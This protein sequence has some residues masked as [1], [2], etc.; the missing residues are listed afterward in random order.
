[1]L[2]TQ[3][4]IGEKHISD[5]NQCGAEAVILAYEISSKIYPDIEIAIEQKYSSTVP[6]IKIVPQEISP[7]ILKYA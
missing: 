7:V 3:G 2:L 6:S 4:A 5:I 1:M